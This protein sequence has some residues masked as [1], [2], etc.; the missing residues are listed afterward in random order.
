[1]LSLIFIIISSS[2]QKYK[3]IEALWYCFGFLESQNMGRMPLF[4]AEHNVLQKFVKW[5]KNKVPL[6]MCK[7]PSIWEHAFE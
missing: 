7:M 4:K 6:S 3:F 1:M 5:S 2:F